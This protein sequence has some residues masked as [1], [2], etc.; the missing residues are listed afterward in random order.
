MRHPFLIVFAIAL[1]LPVP[2]NARGDD[3]P[4]AT[5]ELKQGYA[6]KQS[7]RCAEA[8][9]HF[10]AS[11]HA[12]PHP[13][14]L[15]NLADCE[16]QTGDLVAAQG[17]ATQGRQLALQRN[18]QEL[19]DVG[20]QQLVAID[21]KLPR[22]TI[23]LAADAPPGSS[24]S[25]DGSTV[26]P[27]ALGV[28]VGVN[29]GLHT[30]V[31]S[32]PGYSERRFEVTLESATTEQVDVQPGSKV[33]P[34]GNASAPTI[35]RPSESDQSDSPRTFKVLALT[36]MGIGA[37][38]LVV[39]V[40]TGLSASSK[41]SSLQNN[42]KANDCPTSEQGELDSFRSLRTFST[43]G[44]VVGF[45]GLAGCVAFWLTAPPDKPAGAGAGLWLGPAS[46]GV[47]GVF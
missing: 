38:G 20:E 37:A 19:A 22:L 25:R 10:L 1:A 24:V 28:P 46:A 31:V 14:A 18:D 5:D 40:A 34:E 39:G 43:I 21:K 47:S 32:A 16:S 26:D 8:I 9:P 15:L 23:R 12:D 17:H 35:G 42:C 13:K 29:A 30:V 27:A 6:L 44:Y 2:R 36:A 4:N 11:Y 41:H 3:S 45:A 7:G 33:G